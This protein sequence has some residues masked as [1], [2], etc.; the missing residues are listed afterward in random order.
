MKHFLAILWLSVLAWREAAKIDRSIDELSV[1]MNGT[2][3]GLRRLKNEAE[4]YEAV[5]RRHAKAY[6][7]AEEMWGHDSVVS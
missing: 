5:V 3:A 4:R 6:R 1:S 2:L 7:I